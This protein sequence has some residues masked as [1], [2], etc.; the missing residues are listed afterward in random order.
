MAS[1]LDAFRDGISAAKTVRENF[2][3][4]QR[5]LLHLKDEVFVETG[6]R[7]SVRICRLV[8]K[9]SLN[10]STLDDTK[11]LKEGQLHYYAICA[12]NPNARDSLVELARWEQDDTGFPCRITC[13]GR[14]FHCA[15]REKLEN[16]LR[17]MLRLTENGLK[18]AR[19][20]AMDTTATREVIKNPQEADRMER[21]IR[22]TKR[23]RVPR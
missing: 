6:G 13:G 8:C 20:M 5:V 2:K 14:V 23:I 17:E 19:L 9:D 21:A 4:V 22:R 11:K 3:E 12:D 10:W 16:A 7:V 18:I 1:F 15:D